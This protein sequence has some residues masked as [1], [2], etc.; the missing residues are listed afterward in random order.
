MS[1][2]IVTDDNLREKRQF[3]RQQEMKISTEDMY[4][5]WRI[6][7]VK[8]MRPLGLLIGLASLPIVAFWGL[9]LVLIGFSL[10]IFTFALQILGK[11]FGSKNR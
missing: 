10:S 11:I 2:V 6:A 7:N 4:A 3:T 9:L 5:R 8:Q 1:Q